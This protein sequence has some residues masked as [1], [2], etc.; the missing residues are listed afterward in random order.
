MANVPSNFTPADDFKRI[1]DLLAEREPAR[2]VD[3]RRRFRRS[4]LENQ[5]AGDDAENHRQDDDLEKTR[6][7]GGVTLKE[8]G[9]DN[10]GDRGRCLCASMT[11]ADR[12]AAAAHFRRRMPV[13]VL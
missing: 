10:M 11:D 4:V 12:F 7:H 1:Q 3:R 6:R 5:R 8:G 13:N 9:A 2:P